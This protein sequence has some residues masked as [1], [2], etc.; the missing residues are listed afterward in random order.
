MAQKNS[1]KEKRYVITPKG[2]AALAMLQCGLIQ[3]ID[4]PRFGGFW[5]LFTSDMTRLGYISDG[6][7]GK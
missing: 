6:E 7:N 3:N 4:D 5:A 2:I 1:D